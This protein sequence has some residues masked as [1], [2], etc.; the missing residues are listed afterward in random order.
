MLGTPLCLDIVS[1]VGRVYVISFAC[2]MYCNV[3]IDI[4]CGLFVLL[5]YIH[6]HTY[7]YNIFVPGKGIIKENNREWCSRAC[8]QS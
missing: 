2:T 8:K 4:Y 3:C 1:V 7:I 5:L 6:T